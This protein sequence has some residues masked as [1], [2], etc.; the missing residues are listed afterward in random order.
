MNFKSLFRSSGIEK[1]SRYL[2]FTSSKKREIRHFHV[3]VVQWRKSNVQKSVMY[4]QSCV[5]AV[6]VDLSVIVA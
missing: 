2:V 1:E 4:V 6:L 5:F 3:V